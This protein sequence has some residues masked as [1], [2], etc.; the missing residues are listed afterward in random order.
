[1]AM[2]PAGDGAALSA[3]LERL[4]VGLAAAMLQASRSTLS[5]PPRELTFKAAKWGA[6]AWLAWRMLRIGKALW[7]IFSLRVPRGMQR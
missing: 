1:M 5:L 6:A 3:R 2:T 7:H 4:S